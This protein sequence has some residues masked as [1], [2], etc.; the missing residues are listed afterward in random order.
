MN[1]KG[2][3]TVE[4]SI[5]IPFLVVCFSSLSFFLYENLSHF[6]VNHWVYQA[7][8]CQIKTE[9]VSRCKK[10]LLRE[11]NLI[12][13]KKFEIHRMDRSSRTFRVA[14]G[15]VG[16]SSEKFQSLISTQITSKNFEG[17]HE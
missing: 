4:T 8:L 11:L 3:I 14:V 2:Q 16:R 6:L 5:L 9:R 12:P 15:E 17:Y 1:K 10:N 13:F 7:N